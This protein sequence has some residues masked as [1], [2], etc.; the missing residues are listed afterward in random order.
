M[1]MS[2]YLENSKM[3]CNGTWATDVEIFAS[4]HLLKTNVYIHTHGNNQHA[5]AR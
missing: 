4:A 3:G 5:Q 2:H 1:L